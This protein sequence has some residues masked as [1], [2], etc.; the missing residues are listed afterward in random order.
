ML[1]SSPKVIH[2]HGVFPTDEKRDGVPRGATG[3]LSLTKDGVHITLLQKFV[4]LHP[5]GINETGEVVREGKDVSPTAGRWVTR[6][7]QPS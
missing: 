2:Q 7:Q 4:F 5:P 3:E 6:P 1:F